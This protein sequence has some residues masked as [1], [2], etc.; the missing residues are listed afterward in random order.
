MV[1]CSSVWQLVSKQ[2]HCPETDLENQTSPQFI[3][4]Y[5]HQTACS[6]DKTDLWTTHF[7]GDSVFGIMEGDGVQEKHLNIQR[8]NVFI[9]RRCSY[10]TGM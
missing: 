8:V 4:R 10:I 2:C 7:S 1:N 5:S 6:V 9:Q 3:I